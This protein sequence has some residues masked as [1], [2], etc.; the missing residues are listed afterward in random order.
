MDGQAIRLRAEHSKNRR[1]QVLPLEGDLARIMERRKAALQFTRE[2]KTEALSA[3]VFH[4]DG[5]PVGDFRKAW[6]TAC[7]EAGV[8]GR[9][10]HDLRR[11]AVRNMTRAGVPETVAMAISGHKT[12][13]VFDRYNVTSDRDLREALQR[14]QAHL[15]AIPAERKVVALSGAR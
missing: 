10:V 15:D 3:H 11:S 4:R 14:T 1:G 5:A 9:L 12:R 13:S 7:K 2:D 8:S 6:A